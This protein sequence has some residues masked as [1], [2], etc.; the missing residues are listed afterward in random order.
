MRFR[1][2]TC[3]NVER[4]ALKSAVHGLTALGNLLEILGAAL[5]FVYH[6]R[7]MVYHWPHR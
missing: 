5:A 7:N 3:D 2:P 1:I 6:I 4:P